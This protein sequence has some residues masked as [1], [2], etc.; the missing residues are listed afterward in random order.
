MYTIDTSVFVNAV[1]PLEANHADSRRLL[2]AIRTR[3][4]PMYEPTL[5]LAEVAGTVSR[6]RDST[7]AARLAAILQRL[8]QLHLVVLDHA[9][10]QRA[11]SLAGIHRLR[12]ADAVYAAVAQT[13]QTILV[14]RDREHLTRLA[15]IIPVQH[16]TAALAALGI[17]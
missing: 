12:G 16:P 5:V 2:S 9:L 14:S 3:R 13:H 11:A 17:P 10:A 15:T 8:P 1:E 7:R 6:L 4:L